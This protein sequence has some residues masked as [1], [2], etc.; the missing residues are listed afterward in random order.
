MTIGR[1]GPC[2]LTHWGLRLRWSKRVKA[3]K[4]KYQTIFGFQ[5][6]KKNKS[7]AFAM[8]TFSLLLPI[9]ILRM[10]SPLVTTVYHLK[11]CWSWSRYQQLVEKAEEVSIVSIHFL[12]SS[13]K[14]SR[15]QLT[16]SA[17]TW[18]HT[19]WPGNFKLSKCWNVPAPAKQIE[20]VPI[21]R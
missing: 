3:R 10:S 1:V 13:W 2:L 4:I 21:C 5:L 18:C 19:F 20:T 11:D 17:K 7:T 16:T 14:S 15:H 12:F 8:L 9:R 6:G